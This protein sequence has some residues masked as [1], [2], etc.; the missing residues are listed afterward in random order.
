[1]IVRIASVQVPPERIDEMISHYKETVR[2]VHQQCQGLLKHYWL[3]DRQTG[4]V[5]IVGLWD[6]QEALD[7]A[8]PILEPAREQYWAAYQETPTLEAYEVA[9]EI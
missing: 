2:P 8:K 6:S 9:D 4:H 3:V 5:R 1:M 7:A